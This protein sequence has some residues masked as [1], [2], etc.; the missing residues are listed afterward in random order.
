MLVSG[1]GSAGR[2]RSS[3]RG[4][5]KWLAALG[6]LTF[7]TFVGV[8][9]VYP[10]RVV[11]MPWGL[12]VG[13]DMIQLFPGEAAPVLTGAM[14]AGPWEGV[15]VRLPLPPERAGDCRNQCYYRLAWKTH[16]YSPQ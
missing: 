10:I 4:W 14:E 7:G 9:T 12:H 13:G 1:S 16:G 8:T 3:G 6:L 2:P 11:T 15:A 5:G